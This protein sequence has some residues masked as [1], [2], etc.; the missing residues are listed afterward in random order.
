MIGRRRVRL[1]GAALLLAAAGPAGSPDDPAAYAVRLDVVTP[2]VGAPV[3]QIDLP[4]SALAASRVADL[5]DLR[6]FD[7][8]GRPVPIARVAA[9]VTQAR[10]TDL[11]ASPILGSPDALRVTGVS[12]R[13]G[14]DGRA[15]VA[16]VDGTIAEARRGSTVVGALFD[17]RAVTGTADRLLLD[18]EVP[19][20]QPIAFTVEASTDLT[21]WRP[22]G[23]AVVYRAPGAAE[24]IRLDGSPLRSERLRVTW[25]AD[26]RLLSPVIVRRATLLARPARTTSNVVVQAVAPALIDARTIEFAVPFAL[27]I[28]S[29]GF[30]SAGYETIVPV[31]VLGR[32]HGEEPWALLGEGVARDDG[33]PVALIGKGVRDLRIEADARTPG[34]ATPPTIRFGFAPRS[35][36]F[37]ASGPPP[38]MLAVGRAET[39]YVYLPL[40]SLGAREGALLPTAG[41]PASEPSPLALSPP[42]DGGPW[43]R[44][45]LWAVLVGATGLLGTMAWLLWRR[46]TAEPGT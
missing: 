10:G 44:A 12:L 37:A 43:R 15:R 8:R 13:V 36:A 33:E 19:A 22:L 38:F 1:V 45:A 39:P 5:A 17:A 11:P 41:V 35:I 28:A 32:N 20:G 29:L 16:G 25:G 27:P 2:M 4:A 14:R 30:R 42:K 7:G 18:A 34:F 23:R 3:W 40:A 31:R 26:S 21:D 6:V 24:P 9:G 46:T